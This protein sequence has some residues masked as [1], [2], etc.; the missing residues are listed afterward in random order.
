MQISELQ[1]W[2]HTEFGLFIE[3]MTPEHQ[4][5]FLLE[6]TGQ[7]AQSV[8][9]KDSGNIEKEVADVLLAVA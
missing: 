7:L 2:V 4:L 6:Q 8:I 1:N 9:H 5:A 3:R